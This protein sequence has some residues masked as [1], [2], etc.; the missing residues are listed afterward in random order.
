MTFSS[1]LRADFSSCLYSGAWCY[2][3][4]TPWAQILWKEN[5]AC[6]IRCVIFWALN[7]GANSMCLRYFLA[8]L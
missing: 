1:Q 2:H 8:N 4:G 7:P 6:V 3:V 5:K